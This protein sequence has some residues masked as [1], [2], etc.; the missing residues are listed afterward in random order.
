MQAQSA[1]GRGAS[2]GSLERGDHRGDGHHGSNHG[3]RY[4]H[5]TPAFLIQQLRMD[6]TGLALS[7]V[8]G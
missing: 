4:D 3:P 5:G 8:Q 1:W 7:F 2:S 6:S